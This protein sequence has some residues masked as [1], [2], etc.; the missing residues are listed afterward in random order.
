MAVRCLIVDDSSRFIAAARGLLD[1]GAVS[2]VGAATTADDALQKID[3]LRPDVVLLDI[4]L[5]PESGFEVARR[6]GE[7]VESE[8]AGSERAGSEG[9]ES[10]RAGSGGAGGPR[11][12]L[13]SARARADYED[14]IAAVPVAGFLGKLELSPAAIIEMVSS[15]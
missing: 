1:G 7:R 13:I 5:G 9:A 3:E 2:V 12:I 6:L 10:E 4:D 8:R 14:L 11:V 15:C